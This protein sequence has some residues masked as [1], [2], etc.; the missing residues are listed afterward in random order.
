M[1]QDFVAWLTLEPIP[2]TSTVTPL[3]MVWLAIGIWAN[4]RAWQAYHWS[5]RLVAAANHPPIVPGYAELAWGAERTVR[6]L[7]IAAVALE[8][9]GIVAGMTAPPIANRLAQVPTPGSLLSPP[10]AIAAFICI[11]VALE[12]L[13]QSRDRWRQR[14]RKHA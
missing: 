5:T 1:L 2:P 13:I 4:V 7:W 9:I 12:T 8:G 3:E 11:A 14:R 6:F 10:L